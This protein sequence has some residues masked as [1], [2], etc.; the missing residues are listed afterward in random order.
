MGLSK[1][2]D[3]SRALDTAKPRGASGDPIM[4]KLRITLQD[5]KEKYAYD[6]SKKKAVQVLA[7]LTRIGECLA[8]VSPIYGAAWNG[9]MQCTTGT[10]QADQ[11]LEAMVEAA[12]RLY[13]TFSQSGA[14]ALTM[15][16][17]T[18]EK[19]QPMDFIVT[20]EAAEAAAEAYRAHGHVRELGTWKAGAKT[21]DLG[22][23]RSGD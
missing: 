23:R 6:G 21:Q 18:L 20:R 17:S 19:M 3:I 13:E 12:H 10:D 4:R 11:E 7:A 15:M 14:P 2:V 5:G 1:E 9:R 8:E 22:P 16:Q